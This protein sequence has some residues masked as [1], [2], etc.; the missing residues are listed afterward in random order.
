MLSFVFRLTIVASLKFYT[1]LLERCARAE[2]HIVLSMP[3]W[4]YLF[5]VH[6]CIIAQFGNPVNWRVFVL[7]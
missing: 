3:F 5:S 1:L 4:G 7:F 2:Q 6:V